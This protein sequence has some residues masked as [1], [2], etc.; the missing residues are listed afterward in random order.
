MIRSFRKDRRKLFFI[1][2]DSLRRDMQI[3][4]R[5]S[6]GTVCFLWELFF[7]CG[8]FSDLSLHLAKAF[9]I[10][11]KCYRKVIR[12]SNCSGFLMNFNFRNRI[13]DFQIY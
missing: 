3:L 10:I 5:Y 1:L 13:K 11:K 2:Y 6:K 7:Y 12:K 8:Q 9:C 4:Y